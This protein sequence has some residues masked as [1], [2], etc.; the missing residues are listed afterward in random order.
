MKMTRNLKIEE[1]VTMINNASTA[2][3][4]NNV[5]VSACVQLFQT[6]DEKADC[7]N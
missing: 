7:L 4:C 2:L 5:C 3:N 6:L 1:F